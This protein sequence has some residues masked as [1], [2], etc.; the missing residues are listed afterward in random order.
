MMDEAIFCSPIRSTLEALAVWRVAGVAVE[1]SRV[2]SVGRCSLQALPSLVQLIS[3]LS[4]L[5][6]CNGFSRIQKAVVNQTGSNHQ[7]V[8]MNFFGCSF[9]FGKCIGASSHFR[10]LSW[11]SLVV[12]V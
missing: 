8:T 3:L 7:T 4:T 10:T 9:D 11:S 1:K 5:L 2:P 12:I 6:R